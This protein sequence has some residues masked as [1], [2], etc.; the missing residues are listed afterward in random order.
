MPNRKQCEGILKT[1]LEDK[2]DYIFVV[3]Q[4]NGATSCTGIWKN[5]GELLFM[6]WLF[7]EFVSNTLRQNSP[8]KSGVQNG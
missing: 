6:Q 1:H 7:N 5:N 3:S 8:V 2:P 4:K